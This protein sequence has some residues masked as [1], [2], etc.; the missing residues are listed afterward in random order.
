MPIP[1]ETLHVAGSDENILQAYPHPMPDPDAPQMFVW[2][3]SGIV[4]DRDRQQVHEDMRR[5]LAEW[6][7]DLHR[8]RGSN[9]CLVVKYAKRTVVYPPEAWPV[10]EARTHARGQVAGEG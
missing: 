4:L 2:N 1:D 10:L 8:S 7:G 3:E 6:V 5:A 9:T